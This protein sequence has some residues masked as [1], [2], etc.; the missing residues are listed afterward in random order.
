MQYQKL[1]DS[2]IERARSRT[3]VGYCES[4]HILPKC[5]GG[6][7][8]KENLVDL[9]PE[10]H[11]LC[12]Q[13]LVKIHRGT[14]H[15]ANMVY[16]V[17]MMTIPPNSNQQRDCSKLKMFGWL[18]RE[19]SKTVSQARKS[20][21]GPMLGKKSPWTS[22]RNRKLKGTKRNITATHRSNLIAAISKPR[23]EEVKAKISATKTGVV[24]NTKECP[25]CRRHISD[26]NYSRWHGDNCKLNASKVH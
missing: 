20:R 1:Y 13:L 21:P 26:G 18:R 9:T 12:H 15:Y 8:D 25:H 23:S 22:E 17:K 3:I 24:R 19:Y 11:F 7:D 4:H 10:E 2:L 6:T 14:A 5:M 16:S